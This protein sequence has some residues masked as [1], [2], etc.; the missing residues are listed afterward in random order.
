ML[1]EPGAFDTAFTGN[2]RQARGFTTDSP[3]R[4]GFDRF[5]HATA[6][7]LHADGRGDPSEVVA[8]IRTAVDHPGGP[9]RRLV[10]ADAELV[11]RLKQQLPYDEFEHAIRETLGLAEAEGAALAPSADSLALTSSHLASRPACVVDRRERSRWRTAN[12]QG[13]PVS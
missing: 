10:G 9:F 13:R 11:Y 8:A 12:G 1:I 3:Y 4:P 5:W 7:A 2:T 6:A